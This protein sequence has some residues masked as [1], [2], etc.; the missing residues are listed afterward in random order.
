M[1]TAE[2]VRR[3][4]A[5]SGRTAGTDAERRAAAWLRDHLRGGGHPPATQALWVRPTWALA[6]GLHAALAVAASAL[7]VSHPVLGLALLGVCLT[8]LLGDLSGAFFWLRRLTPRRATQNVVVSPAQD[9]PERVQLVLT[10]NVDAGWAAAAYRDTWARPEARLRRLLHG[11]LPSPLGLAA[12][13]VAV[14]ALLAAARVAGAA[15]TALGVVQLRPSLYLVVLLGALADVAF[16]AP[17]PGANANASGVAAATEAFARLTG[18][19]APTHLDVQLV[20]AGAGEGGALGLAAFLRERARAGW[21]AQDVAVVAIEPCGAG[22][23]RYFTHEGPVWA[24]RL[25]PRLIESA[26]RA[27]TS[28]SAPEATPFRSHSAGAAHAARRRGWP[29]IAIGGL[30]A[31]DRPGRARQGRDTSDRVDPAVIERCVQLCLGLVAE[32]DRSLARGRA[33][34][35]PPQSATGRAAEPAGR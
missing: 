13:A 8:S 5:F 32:L 15:G 20:L 16:A 27:A 12:V 3:L 11:H 19:S 35:A 30:D 26:R 21:R 24:L 14:L 31:H 33:Q 23:L 6:V 17:A 2:L 7:S 4:V 18:P 29:A 10:A 25:H 22:S 9:D 34:D 1:D 28:G